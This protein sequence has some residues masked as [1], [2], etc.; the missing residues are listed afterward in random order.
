MK[1]KNIITGVLLMAL[2]ISLN[3]SVLAAASNPD[4]VSVNSKGISPISGTFIQPW[5]YNGFSEER[6]DK[7]LTDWKRLGIEYVIMGDVANVYYKDEHISSTTERYSIE[8]SYPTRI[9]GAKNTG[10]YLTKLMQK[11][12]Q[13]DIKLYIGIGNTVGGWDFLDF[14]KEKNRNDFI[15][16]CT[17]FSWIVNDL[18]DIY[19]SDYK[20]IFAGFYFVPELY[21]SSAFDNENTRNVYVNA[22]SAGFNIVLDTIS[23]LPQEFPLIFSPYV[24][25]FGGSWVSKNYANIEKFWTEFISSANFRAGDILCPQDSVGAGGMDLA[26]LDDMTKA[27]KNA[28]INSNKNVL[29]WSNCEIFVQPKDKFYGL[30]DGHSYWETCT[31]ARMVEQF[32]IVSKYVDRIFTFAHPHYL[33]SLN[34]VE[35][36]YNSYMH[37]LETGEVESNAP[38]APDKFRTYIINLD[39]KPTLH[40]AWSGM[41]DDFGISRVN[42]YKNN[43][44]Y[45]YRVSTRNESGATEQTYPNYFYDPEYDFESTEN[46]VYQFEVIDCAGN[47][48]E[49]VSFTV[50]PNSV[51]NNVKLDAPYKGPIKEI[52]ENSDA[53]SK[54]QSNDTDNSAPESDFI[55][56]DNNE[57]DKSFPW[58]WL[59]I[60]AGIVAIA[61]LVV[62]FIKKKKK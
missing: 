40:I 30:N 8:A 29:L 61:G 3:T 42:I 19:Y 45:W 6:W 12:K 41:Y 62:A 53:T 11:C 9:D 23:E 47:V 10:D 2:A 44:L 37:Y 54:E 20:D 26:H 49:K 16:I 13:Y 14:T 56:Q 24:N 43:E 60:G 51:P 58:L 18:Y 52:D 39:G 36:Y 1:L 57:P 46:I 15:E 32:K 28:V 33:S 5:L 31:T 22:M 17:R 35:G 59:G 55:P 48:S 34:A 50:E 21:N 4:P 27:Y 7:E 25:I 38:K